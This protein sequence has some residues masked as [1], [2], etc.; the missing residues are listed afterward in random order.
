MPLAPVSNGCSQPEKPAPK[1]LVP[2]RS[3]RLT[4]VTFKESKPLCRGTSAADKKGPQWRAVGHC[5]CDPLANS[6]SVEAT[7]RELV[8][9]DPAKT[10][11]SMHSFANALFLQQKTC[12][13]AICTPWPVKGGLAQVFCCDFN[14]LYPLCTLCNRFR[15]V[16]AAPAPHSHSVALRRFCRAISSCK[17]CGSGN[18]VSFS[19]GTSPQTSYRAARPGRSSRL[20]K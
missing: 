10:V 18:R 8:S 16:C 13:R 6:G 9:L 11:H 17:A 4:H 5:N 14:D 12:A 1:S 2:I 7:R 20:T 19:L 3:L 15:D